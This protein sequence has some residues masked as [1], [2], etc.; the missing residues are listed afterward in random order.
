MHKRRFH[1]AAALTCTPGETAMG[2]GEEV[3]AALEKV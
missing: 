1:H 3:A 2:S